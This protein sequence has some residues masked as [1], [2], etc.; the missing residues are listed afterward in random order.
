MDRDDIFILS[1]PAHEIL[2]ALVKPSFPQAPQG[3]LQV[4]LYRQ[5]LWSATTQ[6]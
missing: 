5:K 6:F 4:T 1:P 3:S 2:D